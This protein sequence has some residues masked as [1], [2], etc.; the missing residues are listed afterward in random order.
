M[1]KWIHAWSAL[2]ALL[3]ALMTLT[4]L[5]TPVAAE[6]MDDEVMTDEDLARATQNPIADLI[7]LPFQ[8]NI[9]FGVG[10]KDDVQNILNIQPVV[11][12]SV[13]DDLTIITRTIL[14]IVSSPKLAQ[15]QSREDGIGDTTFTAW[16]SPRDEGFVWGVGAVAVFPT[17]TDKQL[18]NERWAFGPS[19]VF[20]AMP[21]DWVIGSLFSNVFDAG[22]DGDRKTNFFTWQY[23]VN[24]NFPDFY[25][26]SS[27][28]I[29]ADWENSRG[30]TWTVP[31]GGGIGKVWRIGGAPVNTS[32]QAF[33]NA[34]KPED[35][36]D[37]TLRLQVQLLFPKSMFGR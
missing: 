30:E 10:P 36:A 17:S 14:P 6:E 28:I 9:N 1:I 32:V 33:Y 11:P 12:I 34:D 15:G 24:Y 18:G 13:G 37:W 20:V 21:G 29:T 19:A 27:P 22:G 2:V 5:T 8:N 4:V 31:F 23:F 26:T 7:S 3:I 16:L 35:S 25:L